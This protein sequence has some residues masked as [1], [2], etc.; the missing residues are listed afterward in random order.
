M[1]YTEKELDQFLHGI[2]LSL[3][4]KKSAQH[5]RY[6]EE[7]AKEIE[8]LEALE[9]KVRADKADR[10][11]ENSSENPNN[12]KVSE[13]LTGS[14]RSK[15]EQVDKDIN[16]RSKEPQTVV[17]LKHFKCPKCGRSDYIRSFE[18]WGID[19]GIYKYK[20]INCNTYIKDE[21]QTEREGE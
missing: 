4:S 15:M 5:W 16:V 10:K 7:T 2:S 12:S 21:P 6:D 17:R 19:G 11:T 18:D 3:L 9:R 20:C 14:T 13:K 1:T 8:W